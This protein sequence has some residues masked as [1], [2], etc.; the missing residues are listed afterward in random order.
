MLDG[1]TGCIY[2]IPVEGL[3]HRQV[4]DL[5][6]NGENLGIL[7]AHERQRM[8]DSLFLADLLGRNV[9]GTAVRIS[10]NHIAEFRID[11]I[12]CGKGILWIR[13]A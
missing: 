7:P 11:F 12:T 1:L 13:E 9:D 5:I 3:N 2:G 10:M 6:A 8:G 4:V